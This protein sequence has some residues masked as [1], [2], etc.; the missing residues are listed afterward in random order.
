MEARTGLRYLMRSARIFPPQ[1]LT[2]LTRDD[3][4]GEC[5]SGGERLVASVVLGEAYCRHLSEAAETGRK[6]TRAGGWR[7]T[8]T[9]RTTAI[10]MLV[11][12]N[13]VFGLAEVSI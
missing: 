12:V 4:D 3:G 8:T 9:S 5:S 6:Q 2:L 7:S 13:S 10:L 11:V 1:G